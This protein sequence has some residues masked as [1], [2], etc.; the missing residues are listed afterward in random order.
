VGDDAQ[1][2]LIFDTG[3]DMLCIHGSSW[4]HTKAQDLTVGKEKGETGKLAP[5]HLRGRLLSQQR[6]M[7]I[8]CG[9][10][11]SSRE[12]KLSAENLGITDLIKDCKEG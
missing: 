10:V 6:S 8:S 2:Y 5:R 3:R 4:D 1:F 9:R 7:S 12:E 11:M